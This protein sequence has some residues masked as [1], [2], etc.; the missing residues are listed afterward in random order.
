MNSFLAYMG[1]KSLLAKTIVSSIPE[2]NCYCEVFAGAAW[3][4]FKKEES[5]TEIINDINTELVTL[6]RVVKLHLEE[7]I[8]YFKWILISREEFSRFRKEDPETLT[9]IQKAVRFYYLLKLGYAARIKAPSFSIATT[10]KPRL[11]LLRIE[12]ELSEI[13]LRLARVYIENRSYTDI[14]SRFDKP[15][16]FFYVDPPYYG[17]EDYYGLDI[18]SQE[19][20][21]KLRDILA[22]IKGKFIMSINDVDYIRSLFVGFH[23]EVVK[24]SYSAGG[25]HRKKSVNELL[26]RNFG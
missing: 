7:F 11:N 10:S 24:T 19:D 14:F 18:F 25:A 9:D 4:L 23:I 26:I 22:G 17:C 5:N 8:R 2:H 1:G 13:H 6:Y 3:I 16:T 20:F 21:L 15:D 12:E